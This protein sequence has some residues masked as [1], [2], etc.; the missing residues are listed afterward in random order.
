[1][2]SRDFCYWL[3]GALEITGS[4]SFDEKQVEVIK[5]HLAMV[6]VHEIDPSFGDSKHVEKLQ[7]IHKMGTKTPM[8]HVGTMG[9]FSSAETLMNC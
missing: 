2:K 7:E 5:N 3:Q 4:K 8:E 9:K 1:M 6:F